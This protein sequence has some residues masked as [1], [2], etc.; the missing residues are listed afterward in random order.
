MTRL[1]AKFWAVPLA[2]LA[3]G[4]VDVAGLLCPAALAQ[5][6]G[7]PNDPNN[8]SWTSSIKRGFS[9]V[10]HALDP[11]PSSKKPGSEDDAISLNSKVKPGPE[12]YVAIAHRYE[13]QDSLGDAERQY[14]LALD[15]NKDFLPA[16]L[17]CAQLK[18]RLGQPDDAFKFY[19]TAAKVHPL[20]SSVHNNI[21]L[22]Y[23]RQNHLD[24]A[25]VAMTRATQL[26]PKNPLYRN[27]IATVLVDQGKYRDA[28]NH[29]AQVYQPAVAYYNIGYLLNK[30]GQTQAALQHFQLA[31][32]ADSSMA[33]AKRWVDYL[34]KAT[35][36]ARLPQHPTA[37]GLRVTSNN[38]VAEAAGNT[39]SPEVPPEMPR[40]EMPSEMPREV[41][42]E[43]VPSGMTRDSTRSET[44]QDSGL[45]IPPQDRPDRMPP[46]SGSGLGGGAS[47]APPEPP[48]LRRLPSVS[49]TVQEPEGPT[50]PGI[51][52]DRRERLAIPNAPLP[53][54]D[55]N[56]AVRHLPQVN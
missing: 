25:V 47:S 13:E 8:Q 11:K 6:S 3:L 24:E 19:Q 54:P 10:G 1:S 16:L 36:Q 26:S 7:N 28:F 32:R 31:L 56:S 33:P 15:E 22:F 27:N 4:A 9:K 23:A 2:I 37:G 40:R 14:Q 43:S 34:Q 45:S 50:L 39:A 30:K 42:R 41:P 51:S 38:G 29:L 5:Q 35:T 52:Y 44:P 20:E 53:P 46:P 17:G 18:E 48:Q 49:P 12:L 55:T 21:G